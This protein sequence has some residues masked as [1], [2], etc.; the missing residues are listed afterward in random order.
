MNLT[1][2]RINVADRTGRSM[3]GPIDL[4]FRRGLNGLIGPNGSGKSTLL[5]TLAQIYKPKKGKI[6][7][8]LDSIPLLPFEARRHTGYSPQEIAIYPEMSIRDYLGYIAGLKCLEPN[9]VDSELHKIS[10]MFGLT[11]IWHDKLQNCSVGH[12]RLAMIAQAFLGSPSFLLLDEPFVSLDIEQ[13]H[14][15]LELLQYE[16]ER[17]VVLVSSHV[18]EE[19]TG[20]YDRIVT[21][22]EGIVSADTDDH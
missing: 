11:H 9:T 2:H 21:L 14:K 6:A 22:R 4:V 10:R 1:M 12:Q 7:Y 18:T 15:L 13:R 17:A 5:K 19:M 16:A 20:Q 8:E 3:L